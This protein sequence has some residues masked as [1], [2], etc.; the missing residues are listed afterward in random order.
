MRCKFQSIIKEVNS[1][2]FQQVLKDLDLL[3]TGRRT[4]RVERSDKVS[5]QENGLMLPLYC[6][7]VSML[8]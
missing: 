7:E 3:S 8:M 1:I 4:E 2:T 6:Q 5:E